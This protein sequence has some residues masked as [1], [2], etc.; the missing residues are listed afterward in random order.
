MLNSLA[1]PGQIAALGPH[2]ARQIIFEACESLSFEASILK[3]LKN[4]PLL[5]Q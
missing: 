5:S 2:Q 1:R 3:L 4:G